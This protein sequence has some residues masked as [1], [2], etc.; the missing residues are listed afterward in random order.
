MHWPC[1]GPQMSRRR[2]IQVGA[3]S[4]LGLNLPKLL[5][6]DATRATAP[7]ADACIILFLNGG[8]SHLDMWDPKPDAPAE[9]RGEFKPIPSSVPGVLCGEHLP[10]FAR[11][12]HRCTL[13][14]SAHHSVN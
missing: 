7:A 12:M 2:M 14:R 9:V 6:A 3:A 10:K 8:P 11:H 1:P 5:R 13:I 4:M